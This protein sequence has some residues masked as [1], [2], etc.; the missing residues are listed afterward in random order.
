MTTLQ[1][2]EEY[3]LFAAVSKIIASALTYP[4]QV[5][6]ARLQDQHRSYA[7]VRDVVTQTLKYIFLDSALL[8]L[9]SAKIV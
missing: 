7:G 4:Y 2:T 5:V 1:K 9:T 3:I 8:G 6:R